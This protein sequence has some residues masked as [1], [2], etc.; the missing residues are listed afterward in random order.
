VQPKLVPNKDS[1]PVPMC[2]LSHGTRKLMQHLTRYN[3]PLLVLITRILLCSKAMRTLIIS[4][5]HRMQSAR[6]L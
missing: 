1:N 6:L 5:A 4:W 2:Y 3:G